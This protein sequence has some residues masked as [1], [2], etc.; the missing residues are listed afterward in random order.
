MT[1]QH[2][3]PKVI[4]DMLVSLTPRQE[5]PSVAE[6]LA[7]L[8]TLQQ[9]YEG[10]AREYPEFTHGSNALLLLKDFILMEQG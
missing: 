5:P 8:D 10:N 2:P 3:G 6:I 4:V 9:K 7:Q 1:E